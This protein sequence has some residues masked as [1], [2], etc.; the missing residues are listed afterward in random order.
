MVK[1]SG[2]F[3]VVVVIEDDDFETGVYV[4]EEGEVGDEGEGWDVF[5]GCGTESD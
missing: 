4:G 2:G 1:G 3:E 5:G